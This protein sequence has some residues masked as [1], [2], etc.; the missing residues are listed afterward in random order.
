MTADRLRVSHEK[1]P[2]QAYLKLFATSAIR[3]VGVVMFYAVTRQM[4]RLRRIYGQASAP[5]TP[6]VS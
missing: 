5:N 1:Y 2:C 3:H 6:V 4:F